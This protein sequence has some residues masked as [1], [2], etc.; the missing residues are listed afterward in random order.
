[1]ITC[2]FIATAFLPGTASAS[3]TE[4]QVRAFFEDAPVMS[5]I[6]K[7]ESGFRQFNT[8]GTLL[9]GGREGGMVGVFQF[10]E[11]IHLAS[12]LALGHDLATLEGNLAYAKHLYETS[13]TAPWNSAKSCWGDAEI[14]VPIK[15]DTAQVSLKELEN[16]I[17]Q[18]QKLV[19]QLQQL[20][21]QKN[22]LVRR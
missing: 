21:A 3:S 22:A 10:H 19:A 9:R 11:R 15:N 13:G 7:C 4:E 18:L 5:Q 6:A 20:L 2:S 16:K 12:A 1:V 14:S 17:E 8:D